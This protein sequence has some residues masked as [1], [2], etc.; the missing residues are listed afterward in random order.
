MGLLFK[1]RDKMTV[2]HARQLYKH[3]KIDRDG[4]ILFINKIGNVDYCSMEDIVYKYLHVANN[5]EERK[6]Y[7][8]MKG[9]GMVDFQPVNNDRFLEVIHRMNKIARESMCE[10]YGLYI[11]M[12]STV[13][14]VVSILK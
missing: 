4:K 12:M 3:G 2:Y 6:I 5:I 9:S 13:L 11:A 10:M 1:I 8:D 14:A 7:A